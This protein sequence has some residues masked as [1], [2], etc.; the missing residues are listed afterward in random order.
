MRLRFYLA[1]PAAAAAAAVSIAGSFVRAGV[2]VFAAPLAAGHAFAA[3]PA[4]LRPRLPAWV[5]IAISHY[6]LPVL[7]MRG[8]GFHPRTL[9]PPGPDLAFRFRISFQIPACCRIFF[10]RLCC[11]ARAGFL[12]FRFTVFRTPTTRWSDPLCP[13]APGNTR[14]APPRRRCRWCARP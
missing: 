2:L 9:S 5:F 13:C 12:T 7:W 3:T 10:I 4:V 8:E 6:N 1:V 14:T 11:R